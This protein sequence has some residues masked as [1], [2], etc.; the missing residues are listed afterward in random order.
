MLLAFLCNRIDK[1]GHA[2]LFAR[3]HVGGLK[4]VPKPEH[5]GGKL[6]LLQRK[7]KLGLGSRIHYIRRSKGHGAVLDKDLALLLIR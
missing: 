7:R 3:N 2:C 6:I 1:R 5:L 4:G